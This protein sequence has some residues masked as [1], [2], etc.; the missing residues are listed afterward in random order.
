MD[1]FTNKVGISNS[2]VLDKVSEQGIKG[3]AGTCA[4][5]ER[6]FWSWFQIFEPDYFFIFLCPRLMTILN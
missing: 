3:C 2:V 6:I 1:I 5:C 4:C